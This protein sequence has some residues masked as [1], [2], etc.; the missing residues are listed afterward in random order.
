MRVRGSQP[1]VVTKSL[2]KAQTCSIA[3]TYTELF[4]NSV[5]FLCL[6]QC[7]KQHTEGTNLQEYRPLNNS[8]QH[9]VPVPSSTAPAH[10]QRLHGPTRHASILTGLEITPH[11]PHPPPTPPTL[12]VVSND[13]GTEVGKKQLSVM[14]GD[15]LLI[16][17][18]FRL[19]P[20]TP[21]FTKNNKN[22]LCSLPPRLPVTP[23]HLIER[24]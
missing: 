1:P 24:G 16:C 20:D 13:L 5:L 9:R 11:Q 22:V 14:L 10:Y 23:E 15:P 19:S 6:Q 2:F 17:V 7:E 8:R 21:S 4:K 18:V 3:P 12:K